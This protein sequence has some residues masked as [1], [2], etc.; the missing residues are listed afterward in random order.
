MRLSSNVKK[1][2]LII[3]L[4]VCQQIA[5]PAQVEA[6]S[7]VTT[8]S[9]NVAKKDGVLPSSTL[10]PMLAKVLPAVVSISAE[11][12][13]ASPKARSFDRSTKRVGSG[14]QA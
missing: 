14:E 4:A 5:V 12:P 10:A 3:G 7:P 11:G 2:L 6:R 1:S 8:E 13:V 9:S